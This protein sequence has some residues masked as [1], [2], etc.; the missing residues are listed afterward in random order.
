M[1]VQLLRMELKL[2]FRDIAAV[3][4]GILLSPLIL[5]VLGSIPGFRV[6]APELGGRSV[7]QLYVPIML[8][9]AIA[10]IATSTLPVQLA[11][12]RE[13][14]ILRRLSTTPA[15]PRDLLA[16]QGLVHLSMLLVGTALI[17]GIG[18]VAFGVPLPGNPVGFA[19]A[20]LLAVAALFGLG[21]L[22]A[23][24]STS[25]VAQA[26]GTTVF[27]PMLFFAG[28]WV[29]REAMP[30]ALRRIGDFTPLGAGVQALQDTT[31]GHW[32]QLLHLGVLIGYTVLAW[33]AAIRYFR[34]S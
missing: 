17:L 28:L 7:I 31:A 27:F 24:A 11:A 25:K 16:A 10:M 14:G 19:L 30:E 5:V 34:W 26:L 33:L 13:R 22:M 32:P 3:I 9:M 12:Y 18:R 29:P 1:N 23:S 21:L 20:Y 6:E 4:F 8:A 2:Y 15:R